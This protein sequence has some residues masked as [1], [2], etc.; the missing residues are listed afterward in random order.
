MLKTNR[1]SSAFAIRVLSFVLTL[2]V[3]DVFLPYGLPQPTVAVNPY[4]RLPE[5]HEMVM[6][7][8]YLDQIHQTHSRSLLQVVFLGSS[9][10]YGIHIRQDQNC[11]PYTYQQALEKSAGQKPAIP[12]HNVSAKGFLVADQY[13]LAKSLAPDTGVFFIQLNYHTFSPALGTRIRYPELPEKL[14]VTVAADEAA[15]LGIRPTP[16]L[17]LN[18]PLRQW[19]RTWWGFYR[20]RERLAMQV[21]Q[22][23]PEAFVF[24]QYDRWRGSKAAKEAEKSFMELSPARQMMVLK[25]Y[26]QTATFTIAP[27]N[28]ELFFLEQLAQWLQ[29]QQKHAVFFMAPMN[30]EAL[31]TYEMLPWKQYDHNMAQ[32]RQVLQRY[33]FDLLDTNRKKPLSGDTFFDI[34]HTLDKG[35]QLFGKQLF[36]LTAK[37]MNDWILEASSSKP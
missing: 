28:S 9:P 17:A 1:A 13:Y 22:A 25:R 15:L 34:S 6:L 32:I 37:Q 21:L 12:F 5:D 33:G 26:S 3:V 36:E 19:L 4:Y 30:V 7:P 16:V 27:G 11:Y 31:D 10:T 18:A 29:Q 14:G 24:N 35:G 23:T 20:E 8:F 2:I